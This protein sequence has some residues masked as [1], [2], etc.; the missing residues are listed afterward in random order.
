MFSGNEREL[1]YCM[2]TINDINHFI[3]YKKYNV[4]SEVKDIDEVYFIFN[5]KKLE[6]YR[7]EIERIYN[8]ELGNDK[9]MMINRFSHDLHELIIFNVCNKNIELSKHC[10]Y[11]SL[12]KQIYID[13]FYENCIEFY[14]HFKMYFSRYY[15]TSPYLTTIKISSLLKLESY[16]FANFKE[17]KT[18]D[19]YNCKEIGTNSFQQ[20]RLCEFK[21]NQVEMIYN[22]GLA[23]S[24]LKTYYTNRNL[25]VIGSYAFYDTLID[26]FYLHKGIEM[27]DFSSIVDTNVNKLIVPH[28]IEFIY[29]IEYDLEMINEN[30]EK[31][32]NNMI[33]LETVLNYGCIL[34]ILVCSK[35]YYEDLLDDLSEKSKLNSITFKRESEIDIKS[36]FG[37]IIIL[38]DIKLTYWN[39]IIH[40]YLNSNANDLVNTILLIQNRYSKSYYKSKDKYLPK[41]LY[42]Y[43]LSFIENY[44]LE[45]NVV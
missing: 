5:N 33:L 22:N 26:T 13:K 29:D 36:L 39:C 44:T 9:I 14:T 43:I 41:E 11:V 15:K 17:L 12:S 42:L 18:V 40:K 2:K 1:M 20:T 21:N 7:E 4:I 37:N 38:E 16:V 32:E 27:F 24:E 23:S 25:K 3:T 19:F 10:K 6:R 34:E 28:G 35:K 31:K 45:T 30:E 8:E